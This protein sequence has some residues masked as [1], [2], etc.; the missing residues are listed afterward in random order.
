MSEKD[1]IDKK[2]AVPRLAISQMKLSMNI[3]SIIE[4]NQ[5]NPATRL[6]LISYRTFSPAKISA[7][8]MQSGLVPFCS[9]SGIS[10][11]S[12]VRPLAG[13]IKKVIIYLTDLTKPF[14]FDV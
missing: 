10:F 4:I 14:F 6:S 5:T 7:F 9:L 13:I 8:P 11:A 3:L 2:Q 1:I 12:F